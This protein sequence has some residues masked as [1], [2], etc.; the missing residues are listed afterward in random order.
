MT[1]TLRSRAA[2]VQPTEIRLL[3]DSGQASAEISELLMARGAT[4]EVSKAHRV[5]GPVRRPALFFKVG[6]R[7]QLLEGAHAIERFVARYFPDVS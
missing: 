7:K 5:G 3:L 4:F 1:S 2:A 6:R